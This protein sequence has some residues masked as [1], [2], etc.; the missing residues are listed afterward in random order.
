MEGLNELDFTANDNISED[1]SSYILAKEL[2]GIQR[3]LNKNVVAPK[4]H[5]PNLT[6]EAVERISKKHR[7]D[8]DKTDYAMIALQRGVEA[9][10]TIS[11]VSLCVI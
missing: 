6:K 11:F 7:I 4:K 10:N 9:E 2:G 1:L 5:V 3:G 8:T